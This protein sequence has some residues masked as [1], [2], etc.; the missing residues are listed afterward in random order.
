MSKGFPETVAAAQ[1]AVEAAGRLFAEPPTT[2]ESRWRGAC[3][4]AR[5]AQRGRDRAA[6]RA[7][8]AAAQDAIRQFAESHLKEAGVSYPLYHARMP[9]HTAA[10]AVCMLAVGRAT[11]R[12]WGRV[13][14]EPEGLLDIVL[15]LRPGARPWHIHEAVSDDRVPWYADT[16]RR[17]GIVLRCRATDTPFCVLRGAEWVLL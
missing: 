5:E 7:Y 3:S 1:A 2:E 15:A 4:L 14:E 16:S 6:V 17:H 12:E 8:S 9:M 10:A 11:R 13:V